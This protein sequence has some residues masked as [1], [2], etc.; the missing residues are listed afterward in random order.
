MALPARAVPLGF[1]LFADTPG[2]ASKAVPHALDSMAICC[3]TCTPYSCPYTPRT[4]PNRCR[5]CNLFERYFPRSRAGPGK[6]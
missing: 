2:M 3:C 5:D 4:C 6:A 1:R